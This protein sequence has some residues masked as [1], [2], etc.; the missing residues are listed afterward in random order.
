MFMIFWVLIETKS[1][2]NYL[3]GKATKFLSEQLNSKVEIKHVDF[4][5]FNHVLL[6]SVLVE[7]NR[8]DTL[9]YVGQLSAKF[10][11][12]FTG[13]IQQ[14]YDIE[15]IDLYDGK[16]NLYKDTILING[17]TSNL[18]EYFGGKRDTSLV[19]S[20]SLKQK[21]PFFLDVDNLGLHN[22]DISQIDKTK[23]QNIQVKLEEGRISGISFDKK[24]NH[25]DVDEIILD[26]F[27]FHFFKEERQLPPPPPKPSIDRD[28]GYVYFEA[29]ANSF[30]VIDSEFKFI[31]YTKESDRL[32]FDNT[33][34][35][36]DLDV[37]DIQMEV[38]SFWMREDLW[39]KG[40]LTNMQAKEKSGFVLSPSKAKDVEVSCTALHLYD[41]EL[42][43]PTTTLGDSLEMEYKRYGY[44]SFLSFVDDVKINGLFKEGSK[45]SLNDIFTFAPELQNNRFFNSN[46]DEVLQV[47]G[48]VSGKINN[49]K[50]KGFLMKIG[51]GL[52][53]KG[54]LRSRNIAV[55]G[56]E[57]FDFELDRLSTSVSTLR[58]IVPDFRP[59][60]QFDKLGKLRFKGRFTGFL[61]SFT[62]DG[63]LR[64]DLGDIRSDISLKGQGRNATYKGSLD[65]IEFDLS[66]WTENPDFGLVNFSAQ[67]KNGSGLQLDDIN[68]DLLAEVNSFTFKDY[69]YQF[70]NI[71][72]KFDKRKFDGQLSISDDNIDMEFNGL[73]DFNDTIPTFDFSA[74]VRTLKLKEL[75]LTKRRLDIS[76]DL[77]L[78]FKGLK[79]EDLDGDASASNVRMHLDTVL[80]ELDSLYAYSFQQEDH[81]KKVGIRSEVLTGDVIG[82]FEIDELPKIL[83]SFL[84]RNYPKFANKLNLNPKFLGFNESR[85]FD[86]DFFINNSKNFTQFISPKLDTLFNTSLQ[87]YFDSSIDTLMVN[88]NIEKS[89]F[90]DF[91]FTDINLGGQF[92][93]N[94]G[95]LD[96][97]IYRTLKISDSLDIP[98]IASWNTIDND[99][100]DFKLELVDFNQ[101][102]DK[103]NLSGLF[104]L[105][106]DDFFKITFS[107]SNIVLLNHKWEV[108]ENNFVRFGKGI[109]ETQNFKMTNLDQP[110]QKVEL[111]SIGSKGLELNIAGLGIDMLNPFIN[112]DRLDFD[113]PADIHVTSEDVFKLNG[114]KVDASMDT[115]F[116][117]GDD[118]G[119]LKL[120]AIT[121][122]IKSVVLAKV[123]VVRG[124]KK[125]EAAGYYRPPFLE[126]KPNFLELDIGIENYP[127]S[128]GEYF[129]GDNISGTS[130]NI[131]AELKLVGYTNDL[132]LTGMSIIENATTTVDYLQ[133]S[134]F[135]PKD[136]IYI[137]PNLIDLTDLRF[138]D[139]EGN[140]ARVTGGITKNGIKDFGLNLDLFSEKF[141]AIDTKPEDNEMFYGRGIGR[142]DAKFR[143]DFKNTQME[144]NVRETLDGTKIFLPISSSRSGTS[145]L[146]FITFN[147]DTIKKEEVFSPAELKGLD[148]ILNLNI[149]PQ[150]EIQLV[151]DQNAGDILKGRGRG[152]LEIRVTKEGDFEM[153]GDYMVEEGR[154]LFTLLNV[155]NK[156]FLIKKGGTISWD[157][158]PYK[159][160][161]N[162][163]A[164]Y[165][166]LSTT[167]YNFILEY[168][169]ESDDKTE[170]QRTTPVDLS[171]KLV[172][173]LFSPDIS[174]NIA[175]P[176]LRGRIKNYTDS[177]LRIINEDKNELNRQVLGLI[178]F[179]TFFPSDMA[180]SNSGLVDG[181]IN[182]LSELLSNQL[183]IYLSELLSEVISDVDINFNYR[184]YELTD[185]DDIDPIKTGSELEIR[186]K[187]GLFNNRLVINAGSN[188]D[189]DGNNNADAGAFL[190]GDLLVEYLLTPDGKFKM[191]FY[192]ESDLTISGRRNQTGVGFTYRREFD[193][194]K[195]LFKRTRDNDFKIM[196]TYDEFLKNLR[197]AAEKASQM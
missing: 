24:V 48:M 78:N 143:G 141:I 57:F 169:N 20:D 8:G 111:N 60:E 89:R 36:N 139:K 59:P 137:R 67:V 113:G 21:R 100:V 42:N 27:K 93:K 37:T 109:I 181:G 23:G 79:L 155:V 191:R 117:N 115:L 63:Y 19:R 55:K 154:Y 165:D 162:I 193:D 127:L 11:S 112:Y 94:H 90:G 5:L 164:A 148:L 52:T 82:K 58:K 171:M 30:K 15:T 173:E 64:T 73:V 142:I 107:N 192:S 196:K 41:M 166:K 168:L 156:P 95:Y 102:L 195:E 184:Y 133:T 77:D 153:Y 187:K 190:A 103:L 180:Y 68:A 110:E 194:F 40:E 80:L 104:T 167:P 121:P 53:L 176:Q 6:D 33:M 74:L 17:N 152:L 4:S 163:E 97:G 34:D 128:L 49:L 85:Y 134:I 72:G 132:Q 7:D 185:I 138:Y 88:V 12:G 151:I 106:G 159:A 161:I 13:I 105:E 28:T 56:E 130:G 98:M 45:I 197:D 76:A 158:D 179:G 108:L 150:A 39:F 123:D 22:M 69:T 188:F 70:L 81:K 122:D 146:S 174:F 50:T 61:T 116:I 1:V 44:P 66:Q 114:I 140:M 26:R 182:T 10:R 87:G 18:T 38:D 96:L 136:T 3:I 46:K 75:N 157:G 84:Q 54:D 175:F 43:T 51:D 145:E 32:K 9:L 135:V 177:K 119:A 91:R 99:T 118:Y 125:M 170:A 16:F 178:A 149:T 144:V 124:K 120:T 35:F 172:G 186:L 62:A 25:L 129:I 83:A 14:D 65:L 101:V 92:I 2:Q 126:K 183:S 147:S 29:T 189:I 160:K 47:Q 71:G 86:F 131:G 31:D